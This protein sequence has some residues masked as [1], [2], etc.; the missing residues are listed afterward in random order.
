MLNVLNVLKEHDGGEGEE[1]PL[2]APGRGYG[3]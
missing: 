2:T 3:T 1:V